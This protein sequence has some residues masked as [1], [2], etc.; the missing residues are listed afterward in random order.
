MREHHVAVQDAATH[1]TCSH[2]CVKGEH[3][4]AVIHEFNVGPQALQWEASSTVVCH[5][6]LQLSKVSIA[7]PAQ[8]QTY[9]RA[10]SHTVTGSI[11]VAPGFKT[12]KPG[13]D[14]LVNGLQCLLDRQGLD[15]VV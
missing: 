12:L 1:T 11:R 3:L 15:P 14:L 13:N 9:T 2:T 10:H 8:P 7:P 6:S 4:E 5:S